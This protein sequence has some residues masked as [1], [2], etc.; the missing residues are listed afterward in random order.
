MSDKRP[1]TSADRD[2]L[3]P[4]ARADKLRGAAP[5]ECDDEVTGQVQLL[6][7]DP[8]ERKAMLRAVRAQRPTDMRIGRLE[9]K[10]D[11]LA[12]D[13]TKMA[14]TLANIDGKLDV[15]PSRLDDAVKLVQGL[16]A[17]TQ[18]RET[19]TY[20]AQV[21]VE[22]AERVDVIDKRKARRELLQK[23]AIGIVTLLTSGVVVDWL[24]THL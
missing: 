20:T 3:S 14:I 2:E 15:L 18:A 9:E 6:T 23:I 11:D 13:V 8:S 10:H 17:S 4:Q 5:V 7:D 16:T 22:S 24:R 1:V 12:A 19:V 21:S